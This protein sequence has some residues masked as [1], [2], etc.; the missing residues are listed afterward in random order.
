MGVNLLLRFIFAS[1]LFSASVSPV[2]AETVINYKTRCFRET[3]N[4]HTEDL[5]TVIDTRDPGGALQTRG[6]FSNR[7]SLSIKSRFDPVRGFLT[8]DSVSGREYRWNYQTEYGKSGA[9]LSRVI[10][11]FLVEGIPWD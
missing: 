3:P 7:F 6:I 10:P 4:A 2:Q 9:V 8:W 5:C 1:L 11:G